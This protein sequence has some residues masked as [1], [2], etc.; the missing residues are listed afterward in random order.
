MSSPSERTY[1]QADDTCKYYTY[2]SQFYG[3]DQFMRRAGVV[4]ETS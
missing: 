2:A 3:L 1:D 4:S